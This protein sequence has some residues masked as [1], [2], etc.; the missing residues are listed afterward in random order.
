MKLISF[1]TPEGQSFGVVHEESESI[2]DLRKR[3]D[4]RFADLKSFIAADAFDEAQRI[5]SEG[6][7]DYPLAEVSF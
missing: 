6:E 4:G 1:S 3:L 5:V 7:G 2:F